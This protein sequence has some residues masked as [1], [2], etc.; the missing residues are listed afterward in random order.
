MSTVVDLAK[1]DVALDANTLV[2]KAT[3]QQMWTPTVSNS[4]Q[5]LPYGWAGSPRATAAHA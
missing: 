4:G 5:T 2:T 3:K 1:Y